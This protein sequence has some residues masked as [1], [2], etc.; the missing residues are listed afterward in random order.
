MSR[1][2]SGLVG[3]HTCR[4]YDSELGLLA[5]TLEAFA[6]RLREETDLGTLSDHLVGV[7]GETMEYLEFAVA[8]LLFLVYSEVRLPHARGSWQPDAV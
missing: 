2:Y 5:K 8:L 6:A 7:V 4:K 3:C 1:H